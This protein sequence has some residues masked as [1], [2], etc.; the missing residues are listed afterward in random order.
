MRTH[1][2]LL[3]MLAMPTL[4]ACA[5]EPES[6]EPI[7]VFA[8]PTCGNGIFDATELCVSNPGAMILPTGAQVQTVLG[9]DVN[10]DGLRDVVAVTA[11]RVWVR[12]RTATGFGNIMFLTTAGA[13][14]RDVIAGDFDADGDLDLAAADAGTDRV[15]VWRNNGGAFFPVWQMIPVGDEPIR[16]LGARLDADARMDLVV[17]SV[18]DDEAAVLRATAAPF[19]APV[20]YAV[21]D[22]GD[23]ALPDCDGDGRRDLVYVNG[24]G[25]ATTL[26]ARRNLHNAMLG[27][28]IVSALPLFDQTFGF[29]TPFVL[30]AGDFD[31]DGVGDAVVSAS[32]S[33][34]AP[35]TSDGDCTFTPTYTPATMNFTW[36]WVRSRLRVFD[37]NADGDLDLGAPHGLFGDG[38]PEVYSIAWGDGTGRFPSYHIESHPSDTVIPRDLAF[39]DATADG[40]VDVLIAGGT[41]VYLERRIP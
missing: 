19:A 9:A 28:P 39:F 18:A 37:W 10:A 13:D 15:I 7:T 17:L 5:A 11:T 23:I 41:G 8:G 4:A 21:G 16:I 6:D 12:Y 40:R 33:R 35:A 29:L 24:T 1:P 27:G 2:A 30:A 32:W 20:A 26:R 22:A 38:A 31:N 36:A 34:L 14:Y 25:T 3:A